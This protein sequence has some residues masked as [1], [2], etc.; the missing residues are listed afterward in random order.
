V[1]PIPEGVHWKDVQAIAVPTGATGGAAPLA[2]PEP[3]P[4]RRAASTNVA[5]PK[6]APMG[7][8]RFQ[9]ELMPE[10][11]STPAPKQRAPKPSPAKIDPKYVNAARELR[12][13]WLEHVNA[14]ERLLSPNGKYDVNRTIGS[15]PRSAALTMHAPATGELAASLAA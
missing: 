13:R 1:F 8:F 2:L 4:R 15:D 11:H 5:K 10:V 3:K 9:S 7:G 6:L 12:D 14:R